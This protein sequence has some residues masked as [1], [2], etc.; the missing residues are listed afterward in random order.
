MA[1][2]RAKLG[3]EV[4]LSE[5]GMVLLELQLFSGLKRAIGIW[6]LGFFGV[7]L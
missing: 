1:K 5:L 7:I 2:I 3:S 4:K 6:V